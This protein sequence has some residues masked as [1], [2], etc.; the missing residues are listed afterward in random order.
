M[1]HPP[2]HAD[3]VERA[4]WTP[5][6]DIPGSPHYPRFQYAASTS[7]EFTRFSDLLYFMSSGSFANGVISVTN[8]AEVATDTVQVEV[9]ASYSSPET[10]EQVDVC[11]LHRG[12]DENKNGVGIFVSRE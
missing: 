1:S 5:L 3:C 9:V 10:F 7:F 8:D 4:V 2:D 12:G 11:S 6:D